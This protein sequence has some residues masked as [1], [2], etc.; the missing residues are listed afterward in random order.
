VQRCRYPAGEL[1]PTVWIAAGRSISRLVFRRVREIHGY[2]PS[3]Q[4][5][6]HCKCCTTRRQR[7]NQFAGNT[8][9]RASK[10]RD[11]DLKKKSTQLFLQEQAKYCSYAASLLQETGVFFWTGSDVNGTVCPGNHKAWTDLPTQQFL[12]HSNRKMLRLVSCRQLV[13]PTPY[14]RCYFLIK[15]NIHSDQWRISCFRTS[16]RFALP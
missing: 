15:E 8:I 1:V 7:S 16:V 3:V 13:T 14:F 11:L 9:K 2:L 4:L 6:L 10:L 5:F 12:S